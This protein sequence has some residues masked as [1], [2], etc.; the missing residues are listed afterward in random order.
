[1]CIS[2]PTILH[3]DPK[4]FGDNLHFSPSCFLSKF[5]TMNLKFAPSLPILKHLMLKTHTK[6]NK[7]YIAA[8]IFISLPYN[9]TDFLNSYFIK[10]SGY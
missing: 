3:D 8:P 4:Y 6:T 10:G 2:I 7:S 1:M 9:N 5:N